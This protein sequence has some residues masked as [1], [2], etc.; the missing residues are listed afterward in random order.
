[1]NL[2][3]VWRSVLA[4]DLRS[5]YLWSFWCINVVEF[6]SNEN[7]NLLSNNHGLKAQFDAPSNY[8]QA[9]VVT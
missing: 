1:M 5:V 3:L 9:N 6:Y 4:E 8:C 2:Y 7:T